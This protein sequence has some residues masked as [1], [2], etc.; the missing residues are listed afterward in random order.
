VEKTATEVETLLQGI[1][2]NPVLVGVI[3][4]SES[5]REVM[6]A[7]ARELDERRIGYE[8]HV[9]SAHRTPDKVADYARGAQARGL[10]V[11]IAGAG[12]AAALPG[13]IASYTNLPVIGVPIK[14]SDLGGMDSLLSIVQMP[15]GVP[16]ACMA[17]NGARNAAIF[18]AKILDV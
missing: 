10:K 1:A 3:M 2:I 11:I 7:A 18:A 17:I 15:P 12:K 8:V 14:T 16:V 6:D 9:L 4:G 5:D 13:V